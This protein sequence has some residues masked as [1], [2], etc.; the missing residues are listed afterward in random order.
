L[1]GETEVSLTP[2]AL[3]VET[4]DNDEPNADASG[5]SDDEQPDEN[6]AVPEPADESPYP[7]PDE[8]ALRTE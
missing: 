6:E 8:A 4:D 5:D 2:A 7:R 3:P 1:R